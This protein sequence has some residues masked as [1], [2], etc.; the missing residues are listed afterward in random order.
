MASLIWFLIIFSV[1]V[2]S[3]EFGH[4]IIAKANGIHVV[5]FYVGF[6]PTLLK[7]KKG[8]TTYSLKLLPL[9]GACV[10]EGMDA[11]AEELEKNFDEKAAKK[12]MAE[13]AASVSELDE[14]AGMEA[15]MSSDSRDAAANSFGENELASDYKATS[16]DISEGLVL[17]D[18]PSGSFLDANVWSRFA[19]V[20]AG[21]LFNMILGFIIAFVMV[22]MIVVREPVATTVTPDSPAMAAGLMDGD[23]I[24]AM[25]G[26]KINIY[27][28][29]AL[30]N[31]MF[32]GG[33]IEVTY[34][35]DGKEGTA[36][37]TPV[38][39]PEYQRFMLGI[40]N[41]SIAELKGIDF[42]KYTWYEV[43]YNFRMTLGSLRMLVR[44]KVKSEN[45]AGPVG[46]AVN[47]VGATYEQTKEYGWDTVLVN[48]MNI[49]LMLTINLGVLNLLPIPALDGGR[50]LF[51]II[52]I[53][54]G[55]PVPPK[56]E[57]L[58]HM[59]GMIILMLL[60]VFVFFLD[61]KNV[62]F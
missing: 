32:E 18:K 23:K 49:A 56:K 12:S 52:E 48:M 21:P 27:D 44:G 14:T 30:F 15:G 53:I 28:D 34:E 43:R 17:E 50:L 62:F 40:A 41:N 10:F 26:T 58:V 2:V 5:E 11:L 16:E 13:K 54:M 22:N 29:I 9:G 39:D 20:L 59:A 8:E 19:T 1:V 55:K 25:N 60:V 36:I 51:I 33:D 37:V 38:Y 47:V 6:G 61:I 46:I 42:L 57:A 24:L 3:H 31:A 7:F 4:F 35:R 45:V